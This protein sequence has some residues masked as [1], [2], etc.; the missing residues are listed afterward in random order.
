MYKLIP[1]ALS[2][3]S[4][5]LLGGSCNNAEK[6][7]KRG[8]AALALGEYAEAAGQYR[9]AYSRTAPKE[10]TKRGQ[11]AYKMADA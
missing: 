5:L 3:L 6:A 10:R 4:L 1:S 9:K 2:L 11:V 8:D 7:I